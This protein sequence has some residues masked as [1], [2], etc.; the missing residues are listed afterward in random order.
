MARRPH[1]VASQEREARQ[2]LYRAAPMVGDYR[3]VDEASVTMRFHD[4][5][6]KL[7]PSPRSRLFAAHMQ[8]FFDFPCPQHECLGGGFD[9]T[10]DLQAALSKRRSGHTHKLTCNGIRPRVHSKG[11]RC[12]LELTY[13]LTIRGK[14]AKEANAA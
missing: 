8:A 7:Q 12:N 2:Q 5:E 4:P 13:E 10:A 1:V 9:A 3:G 11:Q 6:G 14:E